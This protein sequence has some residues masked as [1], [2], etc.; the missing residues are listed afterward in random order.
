MRRSRKSFG[1]PDPPA[2]FS[3]KTLI[4][5]TCVEKEAKGNSEMAYIA[6]KT[7]IIKAIEG[8]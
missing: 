6:N 7:L 2:L 4:R 8:N 1:V 5:E 3:L